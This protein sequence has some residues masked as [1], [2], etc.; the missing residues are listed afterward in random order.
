MRN[1]LKVFLLDRHFETCDSIFLYRIFCRFDQFLQGFAETGNAVRNGFHP[2]HH[3]L[4]C[5]TTNQMCLI[6][7]FPGIHANFLVIHG[8]FPGI[9]AN[10]L[11]IHANLPGIVTNLFCLLANVPGI[12]TNLFGIQANK[13][14]IFCPFF[15]SEWYRLLF[16]SLCE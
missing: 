14:S 7:D 11:G 13:S 15:I 1:R 10:F 3:S 9:H 2:V 8:N 6:H 4:K 12:R 16:R 5:I